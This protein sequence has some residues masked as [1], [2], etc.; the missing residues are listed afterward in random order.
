MMKFSQF[1]IE[2]WK[3]DEYT[4]TTQTSDFLSFLPLPQSQLLYVVMQMSTIPHCNFFADVCEHGEIRL[5]GG[6]F[7]EGRLE[8]CT[9]G[10]WGS[11]C[12]YTWF[13]FEPSTVVCRELGFQDTCKANIVF[14]T[15]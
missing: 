8:V 2:P 9:F 12:D 6:I 10:Q 5:V 15:Y 13:T 1:K 11:V 3:H 14:F 7:N 4:C